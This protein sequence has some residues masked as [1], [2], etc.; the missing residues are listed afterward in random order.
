MAKVLVTVEDS[1]LRRIDR[2]ARDRGLTRSAYFSELARWDLARA[3]GPGAEP[4]TRAALG[5]LDALFAANATPGDPTALI[6]EERDRR[7]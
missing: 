4:E 5:R 2:T 3:T 7:A 6:R 1:L